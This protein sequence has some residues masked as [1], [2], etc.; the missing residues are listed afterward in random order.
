MS[1][2]PMVNSI[3]VTWTKTACRFLPAFI[4]GAFGFAVTA[5]AFAESGANERLNAKT[6]RLNS[7]DAEYVAINGAHAKFLKLLD[8]PGALAPQSLNDMDSS[9]R[10]I[11]FY[12]MSDRQNKRFPR[13]LYESIEQKM[14]TKFSK[15]KRYAVHEC[16]ECKT[17]RVF[18]KE[19]QFSILRQ[20]DSNESLA[21]VGAKLGVDHFVLW[22]AYE[23]QGQAVINI[24]IVSASNGQVRWSEQY[25]TGGPEHDIGWEWYTSF[26]GLKATRASTGSGADITVTPLL[27]IGARTLT[28]S[29]MSD[30]I[31]YGYGA[32]IFLNTTDLNAL[33]AMGVSLNG[34]LAFELDTAFGSEKNYGNWLLYVS[35]GQVFVRTMPSLVSRMGL[36]IRPNKRSFVD[37]GMVYMPGKAFEP[38]KLSGYSDE[39]T[40]GGIG[41]DLT[42]GVRF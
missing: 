18:L 12:R 38:N 36:E 29:T 34:R 10:D 37:L 3:F 22:D 21:K 41:Y 27:A 31:Y 2:A 20:L 11:A 5:S 23:D 28:R 8:M 42:L 4:V 9:V 6:F 17:T 1:Y 7:R 25:R 26:W 30:R 24:R 40:V 13:T 32:E 39:A 35:V 15:T 14:I 16:L 33:A 19:N